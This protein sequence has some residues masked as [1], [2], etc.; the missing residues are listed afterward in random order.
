[1]YTHIR[2][3]HAKKE[4]ELESYDDRVN[5]RKIASRASRGRWAWAMVNLKKWEL[6]ATNGLNLTTA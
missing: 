3:K 2:K 5:E 6:W 1:M 4:V